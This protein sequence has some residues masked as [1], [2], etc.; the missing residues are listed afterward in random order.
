MGIPGKE[1][2]WDK[3][4]KEHRKYDDARIFTMIS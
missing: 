2:L 3:E 1:K 4:E